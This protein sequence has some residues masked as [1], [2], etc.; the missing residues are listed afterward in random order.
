MRWSEDG[1]WFVL[2][3]VVVI[4]VENED[5]AGSGDRGNIDVDDLIHNLAATPT[6]WSE[7]GSGFLETPAALVA[8]STAE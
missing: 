8:L 4:V 6:P 1:S 5:G 7:L 2:P 3:P